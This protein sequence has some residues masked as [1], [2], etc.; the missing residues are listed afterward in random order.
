M[1]PDSKNGIV[2]Q[3]DKTKKDEIVIIFLHIYFSRYQDKFVQCAYNNNQ[4]Q[5]FDKHFFFIN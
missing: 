1:Y 3:L 4:E 2:I 5:N